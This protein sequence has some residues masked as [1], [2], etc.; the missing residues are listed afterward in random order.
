MT[1]TDKKIV[2]DKLFDAIDKITD[3]EEFPASL[4]EWDDDTLYE[5]VEAAAKVFYNARQ[6]QA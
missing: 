1:K 2:F 3:D 5:M 6:N 4:I